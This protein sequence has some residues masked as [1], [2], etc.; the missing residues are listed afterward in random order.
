MYFSKFFCRVNKKDYPF[1]SKTRRRSP[2]GMNSALNFL[3]SDLMLM[4]LHY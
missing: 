3:C 2:P 4:A 1:E